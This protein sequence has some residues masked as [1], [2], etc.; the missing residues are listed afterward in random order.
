MSFDGVSV[1]AVVKELDTTFTGAKIQRIYQP[2]RDEVVL[3]FSDKRKGALLLCADASFPRANI[4]YSPYDNPEY[5]PSFCMLLRKYL[6]GGIVKSISQQGFDRIINIFVEA[7]DEANN[8]IR[9]CLS[10]EIMGKHSNIILY[11]TN[12]MVVIDS[13]KHISSQKSSVRELM[14]NRVYYLPPNNKLDPFDFDASTAIDIMSFSAEK[15]ISSA[16]S[17]T[18][19]GVSKQL[20]QSFAVDR[21]LAG[22]KVSDSDIATL[23]G[24]LNDFREYLSFKINE[25][26]NYIYS[27][28]EGKYKDFTHGEYIVYNA[29]T[30]KRQFLSISE[31]IEEYYREKTRHAGIKEK[32]DGTIKRLEILLAKEERK[33]ALRKKEREAALDSE[34]YSI[35]G[36]LILSNLHLLNKGMDKI[37]LD[38]YYNPGEKLT[39]SLRADYT[40]TQNSQ[41]YF[42]K[43]A[44]AKSAVAHLESLLE[45]SENAVEELTSLLY[46]LT[47]AANA[48]E[49]TEV[50]A[51][52][53][54]AGYLKKIKSRKQSSIPIPKPHLFITE[55]G[56]EILAGKN[57]VQNDSLTFKTAEKD[58]IWLHAKD[59]AASHVIL[60]TQNGSYS[61]EALLVAAQIAAYYSKSKSADKVQVDYTSVKNVKKISG[62]APGRVTYTNYKS[63]YAKPSETAIRALSQKGKIDGK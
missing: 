42:K 34:Q 10:I 48:S 61:D 60:K 39:V 14:P 4:T 21:S 13:I 44:K 41:M 58:D 29:V 19:C 51:Q 5:P 16:L 15:P 54:K 11:D 17:D 35:K 53:E 56:F 49:A 43:Y 62:K 3:Y 46:F 26:V 52:A 47:E 1:C 45:Q 33:L 12:K 59:I 31:A 9:L 2:Y 22:K 38:N 20:A 18:F 27:L 8:L 55:D 40:P 25:N 6:I 36:N 63:I 37:E 32:Y 24:I 50:I 23:Y 7:L 28:P 57:S 30:E